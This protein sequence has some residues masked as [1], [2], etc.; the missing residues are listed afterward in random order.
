MVLTLGL[1]G[2]LICPLFAA[3]ACSMGWTDLRA[4]REGTM[5]PDGQSL[6]QA[7]LA[8]GLIEIAIFVLAVAL[9]FGG[10]LR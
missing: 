6:T 7:G 1:L 5:D 4:M 9:F 10:V 2:W 8:L 3:W